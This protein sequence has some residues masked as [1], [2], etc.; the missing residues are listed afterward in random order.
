MTFL[1]A[2]EKGFVN[3]ANFNGKAEKAELWW[4]YLFAAIMMAINT[5]L[6][7]ILIIPMLAVGARRLH[8]TG[9]TGWWQIIHLIPF[10]FI[11]LIIFFNENSQ[12]K[13]NA[14]TK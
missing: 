8:D 3:Y 4:F 5:N 9:K 7:I 12:N 14:K 13:S 11:V 1:K 10:G 2:I 6:A